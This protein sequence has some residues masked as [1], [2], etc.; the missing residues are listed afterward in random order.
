MP[1]L[2][3]KLPTAIIGDGDPIWAPKGRPDVDWECEIG[4]VIGRPARY[5]TA[6]EAKDH[7]FGYTIE[8]DVSDRGGRGDETSFTT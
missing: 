7:I 6:D 3:H 8:I 4:V 5:V 1:Y 2:F